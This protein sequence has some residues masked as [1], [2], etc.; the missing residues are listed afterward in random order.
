M[1][2]MIR[3]GRRGQ[4][5]QDRDPSEGHLEAGRIRQYLSQE[6]PR[7]REVRV[8]HGT[9]SGST[10]MSARMCMSTA[11]SRRRMHCSYLDAV[12][13]KR[14]AASIALVDTSLTRD[15]TCVRRAFLA[16]RTVEHSS[17]TAMF[18]YQTKSRFPESSA[19]LRQRVQVIVDDGC[20][21]LWPGIERVLEARRPLRLDVCQLLSK[22]DTTIL[23]CAKVLILDLVLPTGP[24]R[25]GS[26]GASDPTTSDSR[27]MCARRPMR[28]RIGS[29]D[30]SASR[31]RMSRMTL[32]CHRI[33]AASQIRCVPGRWHRHRSELDRRRRTADG[34]AALRWRCIACETDTAGTLE[35]EVD[36]ASPSR[37]RPSTIGCTRRFRHR[38]THAVWPTIPAFELERRAYAPVRIARRLGVASAEPPECSALVCAGRWHAKGARRSPASL[39]DSDRIRISLG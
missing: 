35:R 12:R 31:A 6:P 34:R 13:S 17:R 1:R 32:P 21:D 9:T 7:G 26:S 36:A 11:T 37:F 3:T 18:P 30:N 16:V 8:G 27:S 2:R 28:T 33:F 39:L 15:S 14:Y 23:G 5:F 25:S 10:P 20:G 38:R 19:A 4:T 29:C 24:R 22:G